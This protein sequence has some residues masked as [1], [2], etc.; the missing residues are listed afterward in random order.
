MFAQTIMSKSKKSV[1]CGLTFF[2]HISYIIIKGVYPIFTISTVCRVW[3]KRKS[4]RNRMLPKP[5]Q[6]SRRLFKFK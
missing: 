5:N 2:Y 6:I 4:Y 3:K 1:F